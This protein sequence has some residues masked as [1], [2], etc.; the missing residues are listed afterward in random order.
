[1]NKYI[2]GVDVGGTFLK[3]G[4]FNK[5]S[6]ELI[7]KK[8]VVT[9]KLNH[10]KSIFEAIVKTINEVNLLHDI[11]LKDVSGIGLAIPCPTKNGYVSVCA[12]LDFCNFNLIEAFKAML[13]KH[14]VV[15]VGNDATLAALG[16][17]NSLVKPYENAV[18]ITLG[19]GVGGGV[20]LNS[21]IIEGKT[22]LGGEIGHVKVFDT[23]ETCGCG[24]H[25]CL[26]QICGTKGI[27]EYA[28][29]Q[30]SII[31]SVLKENFSVKDVF[32]AAKNNDQAALNTVNRVAEYLAIAAVNIAIVIEPEVFIIGGGVSKAGDFLLNLVIKYFKKHA[33]FNTGDIEFILASTGNDAG[34][35]GAYYHA[36]KNIK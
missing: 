30:K 21:N 31:G 12:N 3:I 23:K 9:P 24:A 1:M 36:Y 35:I 5:D 10:E 25:G 2:Y 32:D 11:T 8:E 28:L 26:E 4:L 16:E 6:H 17:N 19:T 22:G 20:I 13:P 15:S 18:L 33:R 34:M 27:L 14:I 7:E 29:N